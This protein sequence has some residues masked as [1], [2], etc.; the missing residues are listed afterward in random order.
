MTRR[1]T[2]HWLKTSFL[3]PTLGLACLA[4]GMLLPAAARAA[5]YTV[6]DLGDL[7]GELDTSFAL[8][9]NDLGQVVGYSYTPSDHAF[10]WTSGSGMQDIGYLPGG[11]GAGYSRAWDINNLGQ[12]AGESAAATGN[13]AFLWTSGDGMQNLGDLPGGG[14][15]SIAL[16][17]NDAGQV[18]GY[19][20]AATG[21]RAFL[22]TS[23]GGMQNL[24]D[25]PGGGD[26]SAAFGIN[27][28]GQVVGYS[29]A[30]TGGRATLWTSGGGMQDLGDLPGGTD[31]SF[32]Q[33]INDAGQVVGYSSAA[34]G[35]RAFLWTSGGGMQ[36]LGDL[37]GGSDLSSAYGINE[38]GQVVGVSN[39]AT[40]DRAFLWEGGVGMQDINGLLDGSGAGWTLRNAWDI[41]AQGQIVGLGINPQGEGH[42]YLL[43]VNQPPT[44]EANGAYLFNSSNAL[45]GIGLSSAG[46]A[47]PQGE[48]I[49]HNWQSFAFN[50]NSANPSLTLLGSGLTSTT[51]SGTA[52]LTVTD[53]AGQTAVDTAAVGYTNAAPT[54]G[55]ATATP[56]L[57]GDLL[58]DA[59]FND[60]DLVVNSHISGFESLLYEFDT[61]AAATG[62]DVGDGFLTGITLVSEAVNGSLSGLFT[63]SQL[64]GLF[65][66]YGPHTMYANVTDLA[67]GFDSQ[68]I[69]FVLEPTSVVPEPASLAIWSLLGLAAI[70]AHRRSRRRMI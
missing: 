21:D 6:Q 18:V 50:S 8:G 3:I 2:C 56:Q 46:S 48:A 30:P 61:T 70:A 20:R 54:V 17:I 29:V 57:G 4:A 7:P 63:E 59:I 35:N 68:A 66:S 11:G 12:V 58:V 42:A 16:G 23:G 69:N 15:S 60:S 13:R 38:A 40:G 19:S 34:A 28:S 39:A 45:S 31:L 67:G 1:F 10:L 65:G 9:M 37:P 22:W 44:A 33:A 49:T 64:L 53:A 52:T 14:D 55:A 51:D 24:G 43:T 36:N 26:S 27:N 32:A 62:G 5:I 47:D 25:L 41:N